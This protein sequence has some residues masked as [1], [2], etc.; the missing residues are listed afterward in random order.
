PCREHRQTEEVV[1]TGVRYWKVFPTEQ[2]AK[3]FAQQV[4]QAAA[5][6]KAWPVAVRWCSRPECFA[7]QAGE[8]AHPPNEP[9]EAEQPAEQGA[10]FGDWEENQAVEQAAVTFVTTHYQAAGWAVDSVEAQQIGYDLGCT[11]QGEERH[12]EVKGMG[13]SQSIFLLT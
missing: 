4:S 10:G 7:G 11:R 12:V 6:S 9:E 5:S 1:I 13:G 3:D 2:K 8:V